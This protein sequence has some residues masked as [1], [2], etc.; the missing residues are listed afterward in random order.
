MLESC[1]YFEPQ[2]LCP[3]VLGSLS[4]RTRLTFEFLAQTFSFQTWNDLIAK[5]RKLLYVVDKTQSGTGKPGG[6][7]LFHFFHDGVGVA[8]QRIGAVSGGEAIAEHLQRLHRERL[9]VHA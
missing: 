9:R 6:G 4:V 1:F 2:S 8:D 7:Y 3:R 5:I